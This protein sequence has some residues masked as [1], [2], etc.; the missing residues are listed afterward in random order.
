MQS[1]PSTHNSRASGSAHRP[2]GDGHLRHHGGSAA[3]DE[4]S[5][6]Q[7]HTGALPRRLDRRIHAGAARSDHE[8]VG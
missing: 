6:N 4:T 2:R 8:D 7:Q 3:A 5:V 1:A